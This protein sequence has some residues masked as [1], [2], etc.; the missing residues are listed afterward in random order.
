MPSPVRLTPTLSCTRAKPCRPPRGAPAA[1]AFGGSEMRPAC[2]HA[3]DFSVPWNGP[4]VSSS[5][6]LAGSCCGIAATR[7]SRDCCSRCPQATETQNARKPNAE[8]RNGSAERIELAGPGAEAREGAGRSAL[9]T[10]VSD[11]VPIR[12]VVVVLGPFKPAL[13]ARIHRSELSENFS[14]KPEERR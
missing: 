14:A 4:R 10:A 6:E 7:P 5:E 12:S 13:F 8:D 9:S 2:R 1:E 11:S 3:V